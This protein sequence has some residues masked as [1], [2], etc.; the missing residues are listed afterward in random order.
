M[1]KMKTLHAWLLECPDD[2]DHCSLIR[3][4]STHVALVGHKMGYRV[5]GLHVTDIGHWEMP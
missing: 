5:T 4:L 2:R 3:W 1:V